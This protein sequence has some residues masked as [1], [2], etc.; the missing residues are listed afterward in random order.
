MYVALS[1]EK[2]MFS[3]PTYGT[4]AYF[5]GSIG[6]KRSFMFISLFAIITADFI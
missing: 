4:N 6:K 5:K 3:L 1:V 2:K